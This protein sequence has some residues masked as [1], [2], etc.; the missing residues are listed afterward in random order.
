M[1][2]YCDSQAAISFTKDAKYNSKLKH[3]KTKY[4][5]IKDILTKKELAI[6]YIPTR[7]MELDPLTKVVTRKSVLFTY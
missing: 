7:S 4:N 2:I 1:T 6:Q 3:I 5:F